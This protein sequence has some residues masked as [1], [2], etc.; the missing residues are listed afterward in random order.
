MIVYKY[1]RDAETTAK[2]FTTKRVWLSTPTALNDPF[3][4]E[5]HV[6][7]AEWRAA[8]VREMKQA[9]LAGFIHEATRGSTTGDFFGLTKCQVR[10]LI[11]R[12]RQQT[13]ATQTVMEVE[14]R[15][16]VK[17][18]IPLDTGS[19]VVVGDLVRQSAGTVLRATRIG[20]QDEA[21][22]DVLEVEGLQHVVGVLVA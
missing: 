8:K 3:E 19:V 4:S 1:R 18:P 13:G 22:C 11:E 5:L 15:G 16:A 9:Q 7:D 20:S 14:L 17:A 10:E 6:I 2:I 21:R 12:L